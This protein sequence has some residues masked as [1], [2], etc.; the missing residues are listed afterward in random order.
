VIAG[1]AESM[2][3]HVLLADM[4]LGRGSGGVKIHDILARGRT[5]AGGRHYPGPGAAIWRPR[6][7][8]GLQTP[9]RAQNRTNS[10]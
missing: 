3:C 9:P 4:L 5:T 10:R 6:R 2:A 1:G 8:S 7:T